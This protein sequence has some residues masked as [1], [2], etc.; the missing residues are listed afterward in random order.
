MARESLVRDVAAAKAKII[1]LKGNK[2]LS[3]EYREKAIAA[4]EADIAKF[5]HE[6]VLIDKELGLPTD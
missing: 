1:A 5:E 2:E 3:P 4:Q 6:I